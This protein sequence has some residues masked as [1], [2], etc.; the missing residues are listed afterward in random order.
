MVQQEKSIFFFWLSGLHPTGEIEP[1]V[2][3]V[4]VC[5]SAVGVID[6]SVK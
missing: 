5:V 6:T 2:S 1:F 4:C 3:V